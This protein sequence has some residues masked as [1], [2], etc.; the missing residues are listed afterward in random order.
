MEIIENKVNLKEYYG[1]KN[2]EIFQAAIKNCGIRW[3]TV[4]ME[5][6]EELLR[7]NIEPRL[8]NH[9]DSALYVSIITNMLVFKFLTLATQN[10]DTA[11][12]VVEMD[13]ASIVNC[14]Q[15]SISGKTNL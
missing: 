10:P 14:V 13:L 9:F 3:N 8:K 2:W 15:Q 1:E 4:L 11:K 5:T 7:E 6:Y 12:L